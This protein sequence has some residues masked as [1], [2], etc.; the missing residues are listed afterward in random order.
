VTLEQAKTQVG[1]AGDIGSHNEL[2]ER[3][4]AAAREQVENDTGIV[5]YTGTFTWKQTSFPGSDIWELPDIRPVSSI[6]GIT[7][8]DTAGDS[9]TLSASVYGLQADAVTPY[10]GLKYQQSWP[11]LRSDLNGITVT[12]VAGYST[13][14]A[15]PQRVKQAVLLQLHI[16]WLLENGEDASDQQGA[17]ER[18]IAGLRRGTYP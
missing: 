9:Q 16:Q 17:Y 6:S 14:A 10:I 1:V 12:L 3:L 5:C 18:M 7:Y 15:V 8:I 13:I 11:T 4:I 2:L